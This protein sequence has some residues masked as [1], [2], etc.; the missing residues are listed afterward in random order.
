MFDFGLFILLY[1]LIK[2]N[3]YIYR[4]RRKKTQD[5]ESIGLLLMTNINSNFS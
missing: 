5:K 1:Y 3:I 4:I 2:K